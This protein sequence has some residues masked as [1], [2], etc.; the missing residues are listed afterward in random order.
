MFVK[1][2]WTNAY[3]CY[4]CYARS[5]KKFYSSPF[6]LGGSAG[7][8]VLPCWHLAMWYWYGIASIATMIWDRAARQGMLCHDRSVPFYILW[9][10]DV[11]TDNVGGEHK[12]KG[13]HSQGKE[14]LTLGLDGSHSSYPIH[15]SDNYV[16]QPC[17][18][19]W[20]FREG[21]VYDSHFP[22]ETSF[23]R[24]CCFGCWFWVYVSLMPNDRPWEHNSMLSLSMWSAQIGS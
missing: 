22:T 20:I 8:R 24:F 14:G 23:A 3:V 13:E 18:D 7:K 16:C 4:A 17:V 11:D 2:R 15:D 21:S 19:R 12:G 10:R 6:T 5:I 9:R 1:R